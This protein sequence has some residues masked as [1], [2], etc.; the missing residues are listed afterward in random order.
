MKKKKTAQA[1]AV[2]KA[3]RAMVRARWAKTTPKERSQFASWVASQP[4]VKERCPC[5]EMSLKRALARRHKCV[6]PE[7]A[8]LAAAPKGK[9]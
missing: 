4:R 1:S 6:A 8:L 3:A 9:A 2:S 5:G 7:T